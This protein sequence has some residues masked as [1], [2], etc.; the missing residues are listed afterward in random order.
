MK[1]K[2]QVT[3]MRVSSVFQHTRHITDHVREEPFQ[4]W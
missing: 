3:G 2:A 1:A 4:V